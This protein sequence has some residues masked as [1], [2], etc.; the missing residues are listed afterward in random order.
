MSQ[1][2]IRQEEAGN[3]FWRL[4]GKLHREDGPAIIGRD[5]TEQWYLNGKKHRENGPAMTHP[6]GWFTWYK[7][8]EIHREGTEPASY[9]EASTIWALNGKYHREDGPAVITNEGFKSWWLN[10][11]KISEQEFNAISLNKE[12]TE[13]IINKKKMKL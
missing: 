11:I 1:N 8:G 7:N 4:N 12:L 6:K 2:P 9:T 10:G 13:K 3:I 5:G